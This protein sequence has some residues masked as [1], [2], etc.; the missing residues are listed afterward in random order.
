MVEDRL[1]VIAPQQAG[2]LNLLAFGKPMN[3]D[4]GA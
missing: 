4:D 3:S 2:K 1:A